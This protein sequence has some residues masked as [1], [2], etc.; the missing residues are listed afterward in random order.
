[1]SDV[2][3]VSL[4]GK[5]VDTTKITDL[6]TSNLYP[7]PKVDTLASPP[8]VGTIFLNWTD[9]VGPADFTTRLIYSFP[10][11]YNTIP[12]VIASYKYDDGTILRGVLG[13]QLGAIGMIVMDAD[14]K[15]INLKFYS[16]N[17]LGNPITPFIMQI[18]FYVFAEHGFE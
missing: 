13:F 9:T 8:H 15:N 1:M 14:D 18:R 5:S 17:F 7:N 10:H 6:V 16:F 4:P 11:N 3:K 2:F 12:T